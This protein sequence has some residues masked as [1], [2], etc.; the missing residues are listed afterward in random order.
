MLQP[1]LLLFKELTVVAVPQ[2]DI[3]CKEWDAGG[4][5]SVHRIYHDDLEAENDV[6]MNVTKHLTVECLFNT[7]EYI[8]S[9]SKKTMNAYDC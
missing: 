7:S 2:G 3:L 6:L 9:L 1:E 8:W 4:K 5:S